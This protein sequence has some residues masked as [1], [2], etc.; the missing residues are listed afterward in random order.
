MAWAVTYPPS[1][2]LLHPPRL[3][4]QLWSV[5]QQN[6]QLLCIRRTHAKCRN[7]ELN[8]STALQSFMALTKALSLK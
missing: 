3:L 2:F 7:T 4:P 5:C 1:S 8:V 6:Y